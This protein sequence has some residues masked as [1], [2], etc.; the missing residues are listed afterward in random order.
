MRN[1]GKKNKGAA[2]EISSAKLKRMPVVWVGG[3]ARRGNFIRERC[4]GGRGDD[5]GRE[6][7]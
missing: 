1:L 7:K 2:E 4:V 5:T 3:E 6:R